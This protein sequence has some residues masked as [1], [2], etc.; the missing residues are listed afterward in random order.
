MVAA[1]AGDGGDCGVSEG[2]DGVAPLE[3]GDGVVPDGGEGEP[4]AVTV[5]V[6]FMPR[7]QWLDLRHTKY[8]VPAVVKGMVVGLLAATLMGLAELQLA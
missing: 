4:G 2:G 1:L 3:G 8:L 7:A 6:N 5:T